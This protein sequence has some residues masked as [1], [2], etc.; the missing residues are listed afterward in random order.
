ME[1]NNKG[2]NNNSNKNKVHRILAHSYVFYFMVFLGSLFL[3]SIFPIK[4]FGQMNLAW[5]GITLLVLATILIIWAQ[6]TSRHLN[7]E[8]INR[9]TFTHGPYCYTRTPTHWGLSMLVLGFGIIINSFF[10][11]IFAIIS[12]FIT[13]IFFIQKEEKILAEKY[14]VPYLEYKK[15]VRF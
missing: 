4:L 2:D 14:G 5:I 12:F 6:K 3:H 8:I 11:V 9:E 13:K 1:I 15:I 10:I 7:K